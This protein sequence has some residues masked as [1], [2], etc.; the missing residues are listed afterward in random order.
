MGA[1]HEYQCPWREAHGDSN[2]RYRPHPHRLCRRR[3]G[4]EHKDTEGERDYDPVE[5]PVRM[6][7]HQCQ[8]RQ[9]RPDVTP[10]RWRSQ[11]MEAGR[12]IKNEYIRPSWEYSRWNG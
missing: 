10:E 6:G 8:P 7:V 5:S 3:S 12:G 2:V 9:R 11:V 4:G 1:M